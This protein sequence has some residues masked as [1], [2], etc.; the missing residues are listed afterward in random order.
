MTS[1]ERPLKFKQAGTAASLGRETKRRRRSSRRRRR[2]AIHIPN[3]I[4]EEVLVRLPVISVTRFQTVSKDWRSLIRSRGFGERYASYHNNKNPKLLCVCDDLVNRAKN[5]LHSTTMTLETMTASRDHRYVRSEKLKKFTG[6][7]ETSESCDG[8]VC[9]YGM[10]IPIKLMNA[11]SGK[12]TRLP[13]ANIQRLH[14]DHPNPQLKLVE[15]LCQEP[16][17]FRAFTR[18]GFGKDT[19]TGICKL[20][21]LYNK[22]PPASASASTSSTSCEVLDLFEDKIKWRFVSTAALDHHHVSDSPRPVF[23]NGSFYWLTG[24]GEGYPTTQTKLIVF[25]IHTEMFQVTETPPFVKRDACGDKIG[26]CNLD[27]CLC[28][29][30][31]KADCFSSIHNAVFYYT[32]KERNS[33][34]HNNIHK[35]AHSLIKE[36]HLQ[37]RARL[38]GLDRETL[39]KTASS[40]HLSSNTRLQSKPSMLSPKLASF[41]F[42]FSNM[43]IVLS[44]VTI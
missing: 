2:R 15:D 24:D 11:A 4:V 20:V 28:V 1:M 33:R 16:D 38:L 27:G 7:L 13:L 25:D 37:V 12:S 23:A 10:T 43:G 41:Q 35:P 9:I 8:L 22:Y 36:I 6:F 3:D 26:V 42:L 18:L 14:I 44:L 21:W 31:L 39:T 40:H 17:Q 29:S 5:T 34:L 19:V 32:W 30:E